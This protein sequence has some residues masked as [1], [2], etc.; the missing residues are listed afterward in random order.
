MSINLDTYYRGLAAQRLQEL[1]DNLLELS[2]EAERPTPTTPPGT[3]PTS[4]RSCST[5]G[6]A[7]RSPHPARGRDPRT[8]AAA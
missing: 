2:R 7:Q 6:A 5:W 1:A 4:R 3:S 8:V